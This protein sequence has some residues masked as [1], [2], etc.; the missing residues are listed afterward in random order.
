M[1][2]STTTERAE[3]IEFDEVFQQLQT[4]QFRHDPYLLYARMRRETPVYRS[5]QGVWYLTRYVDV[6]AVMFNPALSSDRERMIRAMQAEGAAAA[7][8]GRL[9]VRQGGQTMLTADPP[10][11]IRLRKLAVMAFTARRVR[12]LRPRIEAIA[13]E[14]LDAAVAAGSTM[15]L[16][17][18]LAFPLPITVISELLGVP[19]ADRGRIRAWSRQLFDSLVTP[20]GIELTEQASQALDAYMR[21]LI[22][23]RRGEPGDDLLSGLVTAQE[24][25]DRLSEDE[26]TA[27]CVLLLLAGHETTVNL[28][29]NGM[30]A[31]LH[32]PDERRRLRDDPSLVRSAVEELLRYDSPVQAVQRVVVGQVNIDGVRLGDGERVFA[33]LGAANRDPDRFVDPDRLDVGRADNRHLSFGNGPHFCL[34]APLA[35][36]EGQIAISAL[37]RRLPRLRLDTDV[38]QWRPNPL[39]RGLATLPIAY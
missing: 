29:G 35:R 28:I 11:H 9:L 25:N 39:L 23:R 2:V 27:T 24:G 22:R 8:V 32:H 33:M 5:S 12:G 16:I 4:P 1:S 6:D 30:L 26:L 10:D 36:L 19:H 15:D 31:L 17:A 3:S 14:L 21:D 13:D 34:G 20:E 37:V 7:R 18:A 38:I